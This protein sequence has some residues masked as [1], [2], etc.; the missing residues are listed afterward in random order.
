MTLYSLNVLKHTANDSEVARELYRMLKPGGRLLVYVPAFSC[1]YSAM[2][3]K[4]GHQHRDP[5]STDKAIMT[6][7]SRPARMGPGT[8]KPCFAES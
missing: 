3:R 1:L 8:E 7:A 5:D 4:I 2:N 6:V